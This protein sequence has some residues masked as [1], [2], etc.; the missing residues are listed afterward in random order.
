MALGA[1][2]DFRWFRGNFRGSSG[3]RGFGAFG[4]SN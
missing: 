3:F 4:G 2:S 1:L